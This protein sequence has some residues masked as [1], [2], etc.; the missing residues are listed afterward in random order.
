MLKKDNAQSELRKNL[1]ITTNDTVLNK[2]IHN[3][4]L[5][6]KIIRFVDHIHVSS[7]NYVNEILRKYQK[8]QVD[9]NK[10]LIPIRIKEHPELDDYSLLN[11]KYPKDFQHIIGVC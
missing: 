7:K 1:Y 6:G 8:I 11:E 10:E 9:L 3:P 5:H 4:I 2:P